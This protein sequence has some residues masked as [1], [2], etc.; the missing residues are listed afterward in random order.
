MEPLHRSSLAL[1]LSLVVT[2]SAWADEVRTPVDPQATPEARALLKYLCDIS[3]NHILSGQHNYPN[4]RDRNSQFAARYIGKAPVVF[5][6]DWG[7]ADESSTDSYLARPDIVAEAIRQHQRG[8]LVTICWHAVPPSADEP[9]TFRQLP[10]SDPK[11]LASVQGRLLDEQFRDVLTS[12]TELHEHWAAQVDEIAK[13]LKQLQDADVPVLWRP[14]HEMNGDWFWWGGRVGEHSTVDLYHQLYDR[15][16]N[17][18]GLH[19]LLW[20]WSVDRPNKP[21]MEHNK[22]F[23]GHEYVDILSLD[24][25]GNDFSKSYYDSLVALSEGRPLALGEVGN[26]PSA[27]ILDAQPR[28]TYYVTWAGMVRNTSPAEYEALKQNKRVLWLGDESYRDSAAPYWEACGIAPGSLPAPPP[29]FSGFWVLNEQDSKFDQ[30]GRGFLSSRMEVRHNV[31]DFTIVRTRE[32]EWGERNTSEE[33][34]ALDEEEHSSGG[35]RGRQTT[36][37]TRSSDGTAIEIRSTR[38]SWGS[39]VKS[40][41]SWHLEDEGQT[42]VIDQSVQ[43]RRGNRES[44]LVYK[45]WQ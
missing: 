31:N 39:E 28:W 18:H 21:G 44:K 12:G 13:Y 41:E 2:S 9:V 20:V 19:N 1:V 27:E 38:D 35:P 17:H 4:V 23:P 5:S 30:R 10:G 29:D 7:H 25:Y 26:P 34:L 14:Y 36:T 8:A 15:L 24:V 11:A 37:A 3:G 6:T 33:A 22:Y 43:S 42:L 32:T 16:V 45:R 40:E